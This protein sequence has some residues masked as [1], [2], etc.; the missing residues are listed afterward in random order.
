MAVVG[1]VGG[2]C[3]RGRSYGLPGS[4]AGDEMTKK[5][6]AGKNASP[7]KHSP[8]RKGHV[9]KLEAPAPLQT[10][11]MRH[12]GDTADNNQTIEAKNLNAGLLEYAR[13][14]W[15]RKAAFLL[16]IYVKIVGHRWIHC[17]HPEGQI[18]VMP[19]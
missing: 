9:K 14:K 2:I 13:S 6:R 12:M 16:P 19:W 10:F 11:V 15:D 7:Y 1:N 8:H 4:N 5:K 17:V 3:S 18:E